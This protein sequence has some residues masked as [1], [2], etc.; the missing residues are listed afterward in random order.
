MSEANG[1][2]FLKRCPGNIVPA[3]RPCNAQKWRKA[4][5]VFAAQRGITSYDLDII[6]EKAASIIEV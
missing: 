3:C 6:E 5:E 1:A 4:L 2:N